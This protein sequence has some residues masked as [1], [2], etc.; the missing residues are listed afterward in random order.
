MQ[1]VTKRVI[2]LAGVALLSA[3]GGGNDADD[4][5]QALNNPPQISAASDLELFGNDAGETSVAVS[6]DATAPDELTITA[7][8]DNPAVVPSSA[9]LVTGAGESR[10]VSIA[11]GTDTLGSAQITLTVTDEAGLADST[12]FLVT[13]SLA[14]VSVS[15]FVRTAF[16]QPADAQP[17]PIN[18]LEFV[19]DAQDDDFADLVE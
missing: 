7:V 13:V 1:L 12:D 3:C 14:Q 5:T 10:T 19:N 15:D 4:T 8:S 17:T 2:C 18:T 16:Q 9:V 6:D 11:P